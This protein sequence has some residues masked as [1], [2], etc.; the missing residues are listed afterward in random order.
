MW[1]SSTITTNS[2]DL[3][4]NLFTILS[5]LICQIY[6]NSEG[7]I[8]CI[9]IHF[10]TSLQPNWDNNKCVAT[11]AGNVRKWF[12]CFLVSNQRVVISSASCDVSPSWL[13]PWWQAQAGLATN[14][15]S[16]RAEAFCQRRSAPEPGIE[17]NTLKIWKWG[18]TRANYFLVFFK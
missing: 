16:C 17:T 10:L 9:F 15:G 11:K 3:T 8:P 1:K 4:T 13:C 7:W 2:A 6:L 5:P 18:H 14:P 12:I